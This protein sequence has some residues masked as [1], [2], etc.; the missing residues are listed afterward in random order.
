MLTSKWRPSSIDSTYNQYKPFSF[1]II[2]NFE[3]YDSPK[4]YFRNQFY[5]IGSAVTLLNYISTIEVGQPLLWQGMEWV[6][7]SFSVQ[8]LF[9]FYH[10]CVSFLTVC[11]HLFHIVNWPLFHAVCLPHHLPSSQ[12]KV[13]IVWSYNFAYHIIFTCSLLSSFWICHLCLCSSQLFIYIHL[14]LVLSVC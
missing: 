10:F 11:I 7:S 6:L 12:A 9:F 13:K 8:H 14:L 1:K 3:T 2:C 5:H 4:D